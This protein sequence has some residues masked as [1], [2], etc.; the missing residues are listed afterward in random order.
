MQ[1]ILIA[2]CGVA[3][4]A[5]QTALPS[6][7]QPVNGWVPS[8]TV[9]TD[10]LSKYVAGSNGLVSYG[11]PVS[12][13]ALRFDWESGLYLNIWDSQILGKGSPVGNF[14]NEVD[15]T[16]GWNGVVSGFGLDVSLNY[17]DLSAP[18]LFETRGDL[19][20]IAVEVNREFAYERHVITPYIR[21]EPSWVTV[22]VAPFGTY[23]H[24]GV[25]H[26]WN[27]NDW[28]TL[29]D[30]ARIVYDTGVYGA[31]E[32]YNLRLDFGPVWKVTPTVS[33]RLPYARYFVPLSHFGDGRKDELVFGA[34]ID[35]HPF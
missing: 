34:G 15:Y 11:K 17:F 5:L 1:K 25:R 8:V 16:I 14:G 13:S 20:Q 28:L 19:V 23:F 12:Q 4:A 29:S 30:G 21:V 9:S 26:R 33:V 7:A 27:I 10:V 6:A 31:A 22:G 18:K 32:G 3:I 2:V 24:A 35:W